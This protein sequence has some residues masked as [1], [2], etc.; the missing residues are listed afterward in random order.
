MKC[1]VH[2]HNQACKTQTVFTLPY[3]FR[4]I[5]WINYNYQYNPN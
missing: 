4:S 2:H 1:S 5:I 3:H